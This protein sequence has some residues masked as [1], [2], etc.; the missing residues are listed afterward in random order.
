MS[1]TQAEFL[2]AGVSEGGINDMVHAFFTARPRY[3]VYATP[4]LAPATPHTPVPPIA[5]PGVP[6]G[7]IQYAVALEIPVVDFDPNSNPA[8]PLPVGAH[9]VG[10]RTKVALVVGCD[11]RSDRPNDDHQRGALVPLAT[12]LE[13][14]GRG[15]LLADYFG[16]GTG[17]LRFQIDEVEIVDITP[18]SLETVMEC[19]LRM[20]IQAVLSNVRLPFQALSVRAFTLELTRGPEVEDDQVKL[21]G[22]V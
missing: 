1:L 2:F 15:R 16:L 21:Y 10:V 11:R 4:G 13:V 5:F 19:L 6:G 7:G 9:Q 18:N 17:E 14:W 20:I 3:L 12:S 22:K 8:S